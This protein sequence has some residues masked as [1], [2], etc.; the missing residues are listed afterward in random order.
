MKTKITLFN[1]SIKRIIA[2]PAFILLIPLILRFD[3]DETD[4]IVMGA[5]LAS[6]V[7]LIELAMKAKGAYR[8][9]TIIAIVLGALWLYAELAVGLFTNWGS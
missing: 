4:F 2:I 3:W 6:A 8:V 1:S 7:G 5:L 9:Y